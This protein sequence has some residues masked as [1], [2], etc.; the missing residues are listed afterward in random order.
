M[1]RIRVYPNYGP[2]SP[3]IDIPDGFILIVDSREQRPLFDF[4]LPW[5][6]RGTLKT[7][8]YSIKGFEENISIERKGN[9]TDFFSSITHGRDRFRRELERMAK[10]EWRGLLIEDAEI[11]MFKPH[12]HCNVHPN[13]IYHTVSSIEIRYG[14][15]IYY[16][17]CK[18]EAQNWV[19]SRLTKFY[20]IKRGI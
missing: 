2:F 20:R 11:E 16:A 1:G 12:M 10:M 3:K 5:V 9:L 8:D 15:N 13:V 4:S 6:V 17:K 18:K 19:L 14:I 7:G